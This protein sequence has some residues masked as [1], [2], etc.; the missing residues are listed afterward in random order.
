M[1]LYIVGLTIAAL[2]KTISMVMD[3]QDHPKSRT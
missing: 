1:K 3:N 2:P